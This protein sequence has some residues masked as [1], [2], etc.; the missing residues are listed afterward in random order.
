MAHSQVSQLEIGLGVTVQTGREAAS[1]H[2]QVDNMWT[3]HDTGTAESVSSFC[4]IKL[5][6]TIPN[7]GISDADEGW[8]WP[9][10][11]H[12]HA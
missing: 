1:R 10:E 6:H 11:Y 8:S 5:I 7:E 9:I 12:Q 4:L 3:V 2:L